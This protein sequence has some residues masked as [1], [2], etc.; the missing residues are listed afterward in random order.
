MYVPGPRLLNVV[1]L[2]SLEVYCTGEK[3]GSVNE[4]RQNGQAKSNSP[5]SLVAFA[6]KS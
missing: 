5:L 6:L 4:V 1:Q 2:P 3:L